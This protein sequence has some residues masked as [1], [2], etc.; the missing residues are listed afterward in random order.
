MR[1]PTPISAA[2]LA[3]LLAACALA[4]P[5]SA[6]KRVVRPGHS[7]QA[8]INASKPGDT[9]ALTK[10]TYR[11]SLQIS[12][13]RLTLQG[14][15]AT[16]MQ[17]AKPASTVCNQLSS[18][19]VVGVCIVGKV[20]LPTGPNGSP[21]VK[22]RVKHVT[23]MGLTIKGFTGDGSLLFG[24]S[25]AKLKDDRLIRNGGYGAFSNTSSGTRYVGDLARGNHAP[26]FYVGDS[27]KAHA[28]VSGNRSINN[29]G[30]G[31]LLRSASFGTV[32]GNDIEG[33]C[34][35]ILILADNPGP[36]AHWTISGNTVRKNNNACPGDPAE[37]EPA[38]S[39]LG[40]VLSG[41]TKT[42]LT[43]NR[44]EGN[45][46]GHKSQLGSGGILVGKGSGG[47][48][49]TGDR[50]S[51]NTL[52]RNTPF[53]ISWDRTGRVKFK[54]NRCTNGSPSRTCKH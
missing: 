26:G 49:P 27:P 42:T 13:N 36:A 22:H 10:G 29:T 46:A 54:R 52:K 47:T 40:I 8:A 11:E 38:L 7:I 18:G 45:R 34:T 51:S 5:A 33:N 37:G 1:N 2:A 32:Q 41:A 16:L 50:V 48:V 23:V 17:P 21:T 6:R 19:Q 14:N 44:V 30:E 12:T 9:I 31:I 53:D 28:V 43:G 25:G 4:A 39:G 20:T 3:A 15:H 35:G 24:S